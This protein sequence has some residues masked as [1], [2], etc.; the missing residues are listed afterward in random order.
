MRLCEASST[1]SALHAET[2]DASS[3]SLWATLSRSS[4]GALRNASVVI[5]LWDR[6]RDC[7]GA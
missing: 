4:A 6:S 7:L 3:M 1:V 5:R 2:P